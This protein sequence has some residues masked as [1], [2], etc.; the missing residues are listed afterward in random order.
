[1]VASKI[2]VSTLLILL[3]L[4]FCLISLLPS[5]IVHAYLRQIIFLYKGIEERD[6]LNVI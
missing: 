2:Q 4:L 1:L 3:N 5:L 6:L